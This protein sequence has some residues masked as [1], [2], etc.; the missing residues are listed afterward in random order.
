MD[1]EIAFTAGD[2]YEVEG[3]GWAAVTTLDRT[4]ADFAHLIGKSVVID[5][6]KYICLAVERFLHN[7][8]WRKGEPISLLVEDVPI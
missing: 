1:E 7:P 8:P 4:T 5:G 6:R 3:R 2:W